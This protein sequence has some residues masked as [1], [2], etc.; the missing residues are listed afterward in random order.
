MAQRADGPE[1]HCRGVGA[2]RRGAAG[3]DRSDSDGAPTLALVLSVI[4]LFA[5]VAPGASAKVRTSERPVLAE[6]LEGAL[7][8]R[9][10]STTLN[11]V[12]NR[13]PAG[14]IDELIADAIFAS[15]DT[16]R[17]AD[18]IPFRR[19]MRATFLCKP[20]EMV[21]S[22]AAEMVG[23]GMTSKQRSCFARNLIG[24]FGAD[25][26]LLTMII[27]GGLQD[28]SFSDDDPV[29]VANALIALK[30]C[31]P[32]SQYDDVIDALVALG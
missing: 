21:T 18:S 25:D 2:D 9:P 29:L 24:R 10:S 7:G 3:R 20:S 26:E 31:V 11:C 28:L 30:G 22:L 12:A 6:F 13:L 16:S 1:R 27:R 5:L 17:L 4:A 14:A 23:T 15:E 32:A 8:R 19:V